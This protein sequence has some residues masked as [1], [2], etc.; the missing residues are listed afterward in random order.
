MKAPPLAK[1]YDCL[2][3]DER[4]RL[5]IA[6]A[7]RCDDTEQDRLIRAG[8]RITC[9]MP[10]SAPY[11]YA[12]NTLAPQVFI[13]LLEEAAR[14]YDALRRLE[15]VEREGGDDEARLKKDDPDG[16][17][18]VR[19]RY[20][21]LALASGYVLKT[22]EEGWKLFCERWSIPPFMLWEK[23]PGFDRLQR[24]LELTEKV[25]F[26]PKGFLRWLNR[27]RAAG[28]PEVTEI[29]MTAEGQAEVNEQAFQELVQWW[30][31]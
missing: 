5:I 24:A 3:A 21:D 4:F 9:S 26:V 7:G 22:K 27:T 30:S 12:F 14:Y 2:T 6:A 29:S 15:D 10:D 1:K 16:D 8:S 20:M 31:G 19:N 13:D 18:P 17:R 25:A 28:E 11:S 23:L